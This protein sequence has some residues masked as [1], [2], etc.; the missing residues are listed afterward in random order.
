MFTLNRNDFHGADTNR[1]VEFV[2][3]WNRYYG[4]DDDEYL[5]ALNLGNDLTKPHIA[6]LLRWKDPRFLTRRNRDDAPNLRVER[7]LAQ[8]VAINDFRNGRIDA[9]DFETLTRSIFPNGIIWQL[10]LFHIARP[11]DWPI[12]D[13]NVFH[14]YSALFNVDIP[15]SIV[16]YRS[17]AN[18]FHKL[19]ST[20]RRAMRIDNT[21]LTRVVMANKRLDNAL[22]AFG[23]FLG[24]YDD[25]EPIVGRERRERLSHHDWSGD[26]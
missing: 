19:A 13:R 6:R 25:R 20:L 2:E 9:G 23:Q 18:A 14:S 8:T 17:Y 26:A 22:V 21:D 16:A 10:F 15:D 5:A 12:A 4:G 3:C 1:L 24:T 7:V 11:R